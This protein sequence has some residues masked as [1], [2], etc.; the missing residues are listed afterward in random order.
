M[1]HVNL[2]LGLVYSTL[3]INGI[4]T[5]SCSAQAPPSHLTPMTFFVRFTSLIEN[6]LIH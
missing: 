1:N 4:S 3:S 6:L 5:P 2:S